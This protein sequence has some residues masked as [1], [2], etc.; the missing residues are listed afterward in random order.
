M[1]K[2]GFKLLQ[3]GAYLILLGGIT[4]FAM[5]FYSNSLPAPHLKYLKI[6]N[7]AASFELKNLD[8]AFLRAIGGCLIG[9]GIG[10]LTIIYN[11]L[12]EK[13]KWPLIGILG[14]VTVGEGINASQIFMISSQYFVFPLLCIIITW[15]GAALWLIGEK[16]ERK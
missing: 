14:M 6:E 1:K 16:R 3:I 12:R 9:I 2:I 13:A 4:D 7:E 11:S 10:T 8:Y 5:T 15:L